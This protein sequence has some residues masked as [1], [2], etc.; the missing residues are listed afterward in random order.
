MFVVCIMPNG[1][2]LTSY[3]LRDESLRRNWCFRLVGFCS[4]CTNSR[5][6]RGG[7][8]VPKQQI[9]KKLKADN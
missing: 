4:L 2:M 3:K 5:V 1:K 9:K 7:A 6:V 8:W